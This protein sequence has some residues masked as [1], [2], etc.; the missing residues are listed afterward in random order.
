VASFVQLKPQFEAWAGCT[1]EFNE[2]CLAK[3]W[4]YYRALIDGEVEF[5]KGDLTVPYWYNPES[6]RY[7][8][9]YSVD[10]L[11]EPVIYSVMGFAYYFTEMLRRAF[12]DV[13]WEVF[14]EKGYWDEAKINM[15]WL[16]GI[17]NPIA[18][19]N[20]VMQVLV[21][22]GQYVKRPEFCKEAGFIGGYESI[23]E[24]HKQ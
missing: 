23:I 13:R 12:P 4:H 10:F 5:D 19:T 9:I 16:D 14:R 7:N 1:L 15:P 21:W 24:R 17:P 6:K 8:D 18:V 3:L 11:P 20:P 22:G 2:E